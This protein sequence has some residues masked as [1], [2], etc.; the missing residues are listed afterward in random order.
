MADTGIGARV[1]RREDRRFLTG[2][3]RYVDDMNRPGQTHAVLV[4]SPHAHAALG[5]VDT[6][7]ALAAP[8]VLAVLH[9][10]RPRGGR[11]RR[12]ALRLAH[13]EQGRLRH[14]RAA[15]SGAGGGQGA[16]R[17]RSG[18]DGGRENP[19]P[20]ARRG[21]ES[22]GGLRPAAGGHRYRRRAPGRPPA[23]PRR[24]GEQHLLRLGV[25]RQGGGGQGVRR[26]GEG[27]GA[28]FRQPAAGAQRAGAA[29]RDRRARPARRP[30]HAVY[31]QPEPARH[32][33]ADVYRGAQ[34][35][36]NEGAR[37]VAG[38]GR[39]V[40]LENLP[41]RRGGAG[42]VGGRARSAGP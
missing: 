38:R 12:P 26:R 33:P 4:R 25:R 6:A 16:P 20:G 17:R 30:L 22:G 10:R 37:S 19:R 8:G 27:R 9:R 36:G 29:R 13:Q 3:G 28:R 24:G 42:H 31:H 41:L 21:R 34:P 2:N 5:A 32:P 15:A 1:A 11:S 7:A 39:R 35:A 14:G 18:G 23:S 40:R